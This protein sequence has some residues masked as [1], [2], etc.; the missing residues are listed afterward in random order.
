MDPRRQQVLLDIA[1]RFGT[2]VYVYDAAVVRRQLSTLK[3]FDHV[4]FAQKA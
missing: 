2:P 1:A 3:R 4:R